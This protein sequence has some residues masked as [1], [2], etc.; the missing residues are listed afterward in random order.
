MGSCDRLSLQTEQ[1]NVTG[2]PY[3]A[4][5]QNVVGHTFLYKNV[6]RDSFL[7]QIDMNNYEEPLLK[8]SWN[9]S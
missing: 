1:N 6:N 5:L 4:P 2:S 3:C 8:K 9:L 7:S